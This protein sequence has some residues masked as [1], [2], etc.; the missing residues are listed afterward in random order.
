MTQLPRSAAIVGA[1]GGAGTTRLTLELATTLARDGRSVAILDVAFDTQGLADRVRGRIDPDATRVLTGEAT[2]EAALVDVAVDAPG[3]VVACPARAPFESIARAKTPEAAQHF[4]EAL[5]RATASYDH[6]L[7]DTPPVAT[8]PSVAAVTAA[9][10]IAVVTPAT[11]LG[12]D[13]LHRLRGRLRDVGAA[14]GI[15]VANRADGGHPIE[16]DD[17]TVP[18]STVADPDA[19]PAADDPDETFAPAVAAAAEAIFGIRLELPFADDG[20]LPV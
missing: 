8:N 13:A 9:D 3:A 11:T 2:L 5:A 19:V 6:V 1:T 7:V 15:V 20:M 12:G 16:E 17:V 4:E 14:P 10:R 18:E